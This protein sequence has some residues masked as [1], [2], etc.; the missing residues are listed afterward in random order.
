MIRERTARGLGASGLPA[1][2]TIAGR[3]EGGIP[4]ARG[5]G[6]D[7]IIPA[8]K[9]GLIAPVAIM[10]NRTKCPKRSISE[11]VPNPPVVPPIAF[12]AR[13]RDWPEIKGPQW[14]LSNGVPA[15]V[16]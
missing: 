5:P 11:L 1:F 13:D 8:T 9:I 16:V 6:W 15:A 14:R 2:E 3:D 4:S 7:V 10:V 12:D